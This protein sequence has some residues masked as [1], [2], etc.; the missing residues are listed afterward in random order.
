MSKELEAIIYRM[1]HLKNYLVCIDDLDMDVSLHKYI[2]AEETLSRYDSA[3]NLFEQLKNEGH[4]FLK[5]TPYMKNGSGKRKVDK[6]LVINLGET[7]EKEIQSVALQATPNQPT[8]NIPV[9]KGE[10]LMTSLGLNAPQVFDLFLK[11]L[12][13]TID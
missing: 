11:T 10:D 7:I 6:P 8:P 5:I 2:G 3:E 13:S 1:N 12:V 4:I 9:A